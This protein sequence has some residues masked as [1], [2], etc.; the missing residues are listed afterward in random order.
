MKPRHRLLG[1]TMLA[2]RPT[3][4]MAVTSSRLSRSGVGKDKGPSSV[5]VGGNGWSSDRFV[6]GLGADVVRCSNSV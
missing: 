4:S 3:S 6:L 2:N 1:Y 5:I